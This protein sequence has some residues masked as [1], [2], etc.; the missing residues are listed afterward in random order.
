MF[1]KAGIACWK[2]LIPIWNMYLLFKLASS[3]KY[4]WYI[5]VIVVLDSI[6][7]TIF[8]GNKNVVTITY[9]IYSLYLLLY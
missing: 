7:I 1:T 8:K 5:I 6:L 4:F 3:K 9:L 2:S